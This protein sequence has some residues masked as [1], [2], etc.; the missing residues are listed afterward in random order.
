MSV[1]DQPREPVGI[2]AYSGATIAV[3]AFSWSLVALT[4]TFLL[5][6]YLVLWLGW[7]TIIEGLFNGTATEG[8]LFAI[9]QIGLYLLALGGPIGF[10]MLRPDRA[11]RQDAAAIMGLSTYIIRASFW[12]ILLIGTVD[13]I[14]SFLRVEE[15]LSSVVGN[16]LTTELGRSRFRGPYIHMPLIVLSLVIAARSKSLGFHWLALMVVIAELL[17]VLSRFVFSYE[18][19][20]QGDL[21]RFWYAGLF[22]FASAYT[23]YEDGH[24]RVDVL[25]SG[26]SERAKGAVNVIGSIVLG[27]SLCWVILGLGMWDKTSIITSPL[28]NIEVSQSGFGM[29]VKYLMGG[30]LA[31][32]AI[33]MTIQFASYILDSVADFRGEPGR[34]DAEHSIT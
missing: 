33:T 12:A 29:Y 34:H 26:F 19:A 20:F 16:D 11:L 25:Y 28:I 24:V 7:P 6:V 32:F 3:R 27:L 1:S 21:V 14:I 23:L 22:L 10:A 4:F 18:Q 30:F 15:L 2:L 9:I 31:I 13:G 17:I 5:N 8:S